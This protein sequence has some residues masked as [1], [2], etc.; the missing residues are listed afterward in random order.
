MPSQCKGFPFGKKKCW[1]TPTHNSQYCSSCTEAKDYAFIE[2]QLTS[3]NK[4][5]PNTVEFMLYY[6]RKDTL[7]KYLRTLYE[8]DKAFLK[9]Y[10]KSMENTP[11]YS[12]LMMLLTT[13]TD[14][15]LCP[16]VRWM[17]TNGL[18]PVDT[19]LPH[20]CL[21]CAS[22]LVHAGITNDVY[23]AITYPLT[24]PGSFDLARLIVKNICN[25][26]ILASMGDAILERSGMCSVYNDYMKLVCKYLK[27]PS[28]KLEFLELMNTHPL[29]HKYHLDSDD[30]K[31]KRAL[32]L[33]FRK[34]KFIFLEELMAK[35]MH[36]SRVFHWCFYIGEIEGFPPY[37]FC[38]GKAP[39][40]IVL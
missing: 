23:Y 12:H 14:T 15:P 21:R 33:R 18:Y 13:H 40:D 24:E 31:E 37:E 16:I 22:H 26:G 11:V 34:R 10:I 4:T 36:P 17:T 30:S 8:K 9:W 3:A 6:S 2:R 20:N 35:S 1:L 5:L 38:S 27:D 19:V 7:V 39:W 25:I 28:R 29:L 32:Y